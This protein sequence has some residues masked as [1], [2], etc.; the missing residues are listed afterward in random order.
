MQEFALKR[1]LPRSLMPAC[2]YLFDDTDLWLKAYL[3]FSRKRVSPLAS[4]LRFAPGTQPLIVKCKDVLLQMN[5]LDGLQRRILCGLYENASLEAILNNLE[6]D[7]LFLDIGANVGFYTLH[8]ARKAFQGRV[9]CFEADPDVYSQ[10]C[11]NIQLNGCGGRVQT[12]NR[13]VSNTNAAVTF[14]Q[15]QDARCSGAGSLNLFPDLPSRDVT[16]Q[17]LRLDDFLQNSGISSVSCAKIDVEGSEFQLL[18]GARQALENGVIKNILIEFNG[19]RL[20][21]L[22]RSLPEFCAIFDEHRYVCRFNRP[23]LEDAK[24]GLIDPTGMCENFLFS[25]VS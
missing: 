1:L 23:V 7:G 8:A 20:Y 3:A 21:E 25:L 17:A 4:C 18:E 10:L 14:R 5:P 15:S 19:P 12:Y 24:K 13:A 16:V 9:F 2:K 6:P 22:G 11:A